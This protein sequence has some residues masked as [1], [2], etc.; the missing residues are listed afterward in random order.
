MTYSIKMRVGRTIRRETSV[1]D[2]L[3]FRSQAQLCYFGGDLMSEYSI[4]VYVLNHSLD[5]PF[6]RQL[7]ERKGPAHLFDKKFE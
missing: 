1:G 4:Q 2:R 3:L 5:D 7:I 6:T